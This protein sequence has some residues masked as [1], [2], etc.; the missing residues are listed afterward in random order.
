MALEDS[1]ILGLVF[2]VS[3]LFI[4]GVYLMSRQNQTPVFGN[5]LEAFKIGDFGFILIMI[6]VMALNTIPATLLEMGAGQPYYNI[7]QVVW[8]ISIIVTIL[9]TVICSFFYIFLRTMMSSLEQVNTQK[10]A[11]R[12]K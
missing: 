2:F 9:S 6:S 3:S 1:I 7:L 4:F 12:G 10:S 11:F 8:Q 5:F